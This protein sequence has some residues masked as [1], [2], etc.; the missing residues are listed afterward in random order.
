MIGDEEEIT[1][2]KENKKKIEWEIRDKEDRERINIYR[3]K[4]RGLTN[5]LTTI[6]EDAGLSI[7]A[8]FLFGDDAL[9]V[10]KD[11]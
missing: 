1:Y 2:F 5:K 8:I 10:R 3:T 7:S 6:I 9:Y 4:I 11:E